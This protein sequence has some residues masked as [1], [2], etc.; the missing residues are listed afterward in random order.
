[1]TGSSS[2]VGSEQ[3]HPYLQDLEE[4]FRKGIIPSRESFRAMLGLDLMLKVR[5][6][7]IHS[8]QEAFPLLM[9]DFKIEGIN[10]PETFWATFQLMGNDF[11][12]RRVNVMISDLHT[13][14]SVS[15]FESTF[16]GRGVKYATL[17]EGL[18]LIYQNPTATDRLPFVT[19]HE[20][21]D[22]ERAAVFIGSLSGGKRRVI[23][24]KPIDF[25]FRGC[26]HLIVIP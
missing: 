4:A 2:A 9:G 26:R 24:F 6:D 15:E 13:P 7:Y 11:E 3:L 17:G 16:R 5:V 8:I 18:S 19:V 14:T 21:S 23:R 20:F 25:K 22:G 1:M 12:I 10:D